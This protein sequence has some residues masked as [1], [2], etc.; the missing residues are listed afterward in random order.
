MMKTNKLLVLAALGLAGLSTATAGTTDLLLGFND[1]AG[2]NAAQND[3]VINLGL[4]G[5]GL[6]AAA[7]ANSGTYDLSSLLLAGTFSTAFG[8][9]SSA[10]NNVS[11]GV[12]GSLTGSSPSYLFQTV[13]TGGGAPAPAFV[14][15]FNK[16]AA[17]ASASTVGEYSS[18]STTGWSYNVAASPTS[19]G[20]A[21]LT[22]A[23]DV[24]DQTGNPLDQLS[25]GVASLDLWQLTKT[26]TSSLGS[27]VDDG[28]FNINLNS[29]TITFTAAPAPEPAGASLL[30]AG[31]GLLVIA[32]R[33]QLKRK[34]V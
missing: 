25:S 19:P 7:N 8:A 18:S 32:F 26:G 4:T 6:V 27:W 17:S 10:L 31:A 30:A 2:P 16:A 34:H 20:G 1:A 29:D 15:E 11:V 28:T 22:T 24:A 23:G 21:S 5:S 33:N 14:G 13:V 3:Y 9:D 12:V